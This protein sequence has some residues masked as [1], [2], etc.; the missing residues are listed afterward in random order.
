MKNTEKEEL[1]NKINQATLVSFDVFDTL[2]FRKVNSPEVIFDLVGK[3][4]E[5][6]GFRKLRMDEQDIASRRVYEKYQYPHANM[7]EIY[8]SL[9]QHKEIPVDWE[10][11]KEYEMQ[12]EKD[13]LVANTEMLEIFQYVKQAGKK[14]VATSDMYLSAAFLKSVLEENG[15]VGFDHVYCSADEHKAK[16]N[17]EL[18]EYVATREKVNYKDILHIGDKAR[19]DGEIPAS[20]GINTHIYNREVDLK[21][22]QNAQASDIDNGLYKILYNPNKS[23]MYNLGVEVGGPLYMGL[24]LWLSEKI[25]NSDKTIYFLSRDG[26]NLYHIF[27]DLGYKNIEYLYTSRRALIMAGITQ[28][29]ETDISVLPPYT[30]GQ[31]VKEIL[32]YLFIPTE[33]INHLKQAG[34]KSFDEVIR[35]KEDM[36]KFHELYRLDKEV[37]LERCQYERENAKKYMEK[38]GFL[39]KDTI[40]FDCGWNGSSQKLL[41]RFKKAIGCEYQNFFYYFGIQNTIKSRRQLHGKHYEAYAFDFY[42]NYA[43]QNCV[44]EAVVMYELFF[45]AP[46][47][48]VYYYSEDEI[49]F[50]EGAG[51]S[52]RE[53][54][55]KGI[56]DY[57]H[58]AIPFTEKYPVEYSPEIASGHLERLIKKPTNEEAVILGNINNV[59]GFANQNGMKKYIAYVTKEQLEENPDVEIYWMNG[60]LRR[61][62]IS[63]DLKLKIA[64]QRNVNYPP[65]EISDYHLEDEQ[66]IRDYHR[67]I[68]KA[69]KDKTAQEK[70]EYEPK[71]SVVI[72]VYNTI[73]EQLT[74]A[75]DSVLAQ[76]Y[77]NYELILIDDHSSF[78]NVV[79]ILKS[80]EENSHVKVIYR[81]TN[82]HISVATNDGINIATGEFL[83]FM[84]CD[85][86]IEPDALYEFAK[87]LNENPELDFIYSDEDKITEDGKIKHMPFFKPDWSPDM[88]M[89]MMYTNHLAVYRLSKVKEIGGLRTAFNGCQDYDMTLRFMEISDNK[90]VGH[91]P[92]ILYHW[93]ERKESVAFNMNS[94]NYATEAT[95]YAKQETLKRRNIAGYMEYIV[96]MNQYRTVYKPVKNPLVSIIIPSKDHLSILKQCIDSIKAFTDYINY[97][98][99]VVDN[100]SEENNRIKIEKYLE[101]IKAKYIYEKAAFNFS[102]MCNCGVRESTGEYVLFLND[103]IEIFQRDW[104]TRMLGQAQQKHTGAVGA[105]L[106]Y[107]E[108]TQIQHAGVS[109]IKEGPSHNFLYLDDSIPYGFGYNWIDY[110]CLVVTGACLLINKNKFQQI[111]GFDE[112]FPIAYN[113]VDLCFR[114]NNAGFYNVIRNDVVA[115]H[116]E[117]LS[118]GTDEIDEKKILRLSAEKLA[119]YTKHPN[120][121]GK[122][123]YLNENL[124]NYGPTLDLNENYDE[125]LCC[126]V[127]NAV[128]GVMGS[129]DSVNVLNHIQIIGWS[130]LPEQGNNSEVQRYLILEDVSKNQYKVALNNIPRPD[131]VE[132]LGGRED[133]LMCGFECMIDRNIIRTDLMKYKLGILM[134]D[135]EGIEHILWTKQTTS[136]TEKTNNQLEYAEKILTDNYKQ[137]VPSKKFDYNIEEY[138]IRDNEIFIKGWI[139]YDANNQYRYKKQIFL[140]QADGKGILFTT[141]ERERIDVAI[142]FPDQHFLYNLGFECHIQNKDLQ[143]GQQYEIV[144]HLTN[145]FEENDAIDIETGKMIK[146]DL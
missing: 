68:R 127:K 130:Y 73:T 46:H 63:E 26:Y 88:F 22:V 95:R 9:A 36:E 32:D 58:M 99:I 117:S 145:Q 50:E 65:S 85:D 129:I 72:P 54:M 44:K 7:E 48:S 55:L 47:E 27:K 126:D 21:K 120:L 123:P 53:E 97:E 114:L 8:E 77:D 38:I 12:M 3:H 62:D 101:S 64:K 131:V 119:L 19:D 79:P 11:V 39:D 74:A 6:Y 81:Q 5:I 78:E 18:F 34:F 100:G 96:G 87:K 143:K 146:I 31:T 13:A 10:K 103:D 125:L 102:A 25:K 121:K 14:V 67:W 41:D 84:D 109:N 2:L 82:G 138:E 124:H 69:K 59:D 4:F 28:M 116:H 35:N 57:L 49:V 141:C 136:I 92:K 106:F 76:T 16:F 20:F 89:S 83:A 56:M 61:E 142:E 91:I 118:R 43:L 144:L 17:K 110:N 42:K 132:N 80:Y 111:G 107:P 52:E 115:Y 90:K 60:L 66:S 105:K 112:E 122:D 24:F 108:T 23:F 137:N 104:L 70:L 140:K 15:F 75:I 86:M 133:L 94:K 128:G 40:V 37:F 113:D 45:S 71:F 135:S 29:N 98:I 1:K 139:L 33:K 134:I 30:F 93:R 51:N